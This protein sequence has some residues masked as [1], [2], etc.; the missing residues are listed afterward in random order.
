MFANEQAGGNWQHVKPDGQV[1][2]TSTVKVDVTDGRL[3]LDSKDSANKNIQIN[4]IQIKPLPSQTKEVKINHQTLYSQTPDGF[5]A[6]IGELYGS[7]GNG[8]TYGWSR[9]NTG[10]TRDYSLLEPD[11][12][13]ATLNQFGAGYL[14]EIAVPNGKYEVTVS[15]GDIL[16][17][18][19]IKGKLLLT[20]EDKVLFENQQVDGV[21]KH[22]KPDGQVY[23]ASTVEVQVTDGKLTLDPKDSAGKNIKINYI[24]IKALTTP[25]TVDPVELGPVLSMPAIDTTPVTVQIQGE[26]VKSKDPVIRA[27]GQV[28]VS[29]S[30]IEENLGVEVAWDEEKQAVLVDSLPGQARLKQPEIQLIVKGL[31]LNPEVSPFYWEETTMLPLREIA[32]ALGWTVAWDA[33]SLSMSLT[34]QALAA[35]STDLYG[36]ASVDAEGVNGTTGGGQATPQTVTTLAELE[37]L[38]GDDVPRVIIVSGTITSGADFIHVGSNKTIQGADKHATIRGGI[39]IDNES[40]IIVRNLNMEGVWPIYGPADT[41]AVRYSHHL[42][43]DHLTIWDASDGLLD[44]TQGTNYVTVSWN[45]FFYTERSHPHR[46]ASLNGGGAEHEDTD[47]GRNKVTYHHNW[48]AN[49]VDQRMPRVLFGQ[50]HAYNNYYTASG[51]SYAIGVGVYA[52]MLIEN[53]YFKNVN[54]PHQFMYPDRRPAYITAVGNVYDNTTGSKDTGGVTPEGYTPVEP[55]T[56]PPYAYEPDPAQD[57][58]SLVAQY[59]GVQ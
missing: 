15:I 3:T 19:Q 47:T 2:A 45:K 14:W 48:Y 16:Y 11:L 13:L 57:V 52:S 41:I 30:F 50:A 36:W 23:A 17:P 59:A 8:F 34:R 26:K 6:D 37:A 40:N 39:T 12:K 9:L 25:I 33:S 38:A 54:N 21:W 55:F 49:N 10:E 56:N 18:N 46:L 1:Y 53:N 4:Y 42:W 22:V 24:D 51:N 32:E 43:F 44:L 27:D 20:A 31:E 58:P 5:V 35:P 28:V 7:R 29:Q